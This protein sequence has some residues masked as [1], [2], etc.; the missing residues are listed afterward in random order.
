[1]TASLSDRLAAGALRQHLLPS[2]VLQR[3]IPPGC[4]SPLNCGDVDCGDCNDCC[5]EQSGGDCP[6]ICIEIGELETCLC[7]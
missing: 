4:F 3:E 7:T 6:G 2:A 5:S 1:M